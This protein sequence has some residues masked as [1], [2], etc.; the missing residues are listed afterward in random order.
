MSRVNRPSSEQVVQFLDATNDFLR[1]ATNSAVQRLIEGMDLL[2]CVAYGEEPLPDLRKR[3]NLGFL[4]PVDYNLTVYEMSVRSCC[5]VEDSLSEAGH[6]FLGLGQVFVLFEFLNLSESELLAAEPSDV[7]REKG[8]R[9]AT[10]AG[11]FSFLAGYCGKIPRNGS[12]TIAAGQLF[13]KSVRRG[14]YGN[15]PG[16]DILRC[17]WGADWRNQKLHAEL[18]P[19]GALRPSDTFLVVRTGQ[20]S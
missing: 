16:R 3:L 5:H 12:R 10:V 8:F 19:I 9:P 17:Y 20:G 18:V 13:H 4:M 1:E 2:K 7:I 14:A 11:F 6:P 15:L